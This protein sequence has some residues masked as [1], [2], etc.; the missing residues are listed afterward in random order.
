MMAE[1]EGAGIADE[2]FETRVFETDHGSLPYRLLRPKDYDPQH[3]YPLVIF[4][5][6]AGER[7]DD[8]VKQLVHGMN[9]FASDDVMAKYRCFVIAPQ[10]PSGKQ[11]VDVPWSAD[12]HKMPEEPALPM[13]LSLE[14]INSLQAEFPIDA[15]RLYVTG[16]SM[17]GFGTWDAIQRHPNR[18]AAA[19]PICG[20]GDATSVQPI[21][22]LPIWAFHGDADTAV[23]PKRSRDMIAA[24]KAAGG[25]PKY[26]EYPGVGHNSWAPT[27]ANR[28]MYAWLFSQKRTT[29]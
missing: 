22:N 12:A 6:G 7:G 10:C 1:V 2:R 17:G 16:L 24:L 25:A 4:Y 21:A 3:S 20:G 5:H 11:W 14:L 29:R 19:V 27:Y 23:K 18:F 8:N 15:D 26:T 13:R 28:E 9:D